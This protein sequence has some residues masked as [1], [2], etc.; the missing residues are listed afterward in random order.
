MRYVLTCTCSGSLTRL[1]NTVE[2]MAVRLDEVHNLVVGDMNDKIAD[3]YNLMVTMA[4]QFDNEAGSPTLS[5]S[6]KATKIAGKISYEELTNASS[7]PRAKSADS[8]EEFRQT[9]GAPKEGMKYALDVAKKQKYN[10][11]DLR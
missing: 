2:P 3:I 1:E 7:Y 4:S 10:Q 5:P 6:V 8:T 11:E 9:D